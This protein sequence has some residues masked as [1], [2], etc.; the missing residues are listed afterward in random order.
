MKRF[1]RDFNV[2]RACIYPGQDDRYRVFMLPLST[3]TTEYPENNRLQRNLKAWLLEG[4]TMGAGFGL[5]LW[6]EGIIS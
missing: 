5:F 4:N 2:V 1:S 3:P 6:K